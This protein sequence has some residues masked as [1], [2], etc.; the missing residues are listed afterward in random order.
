MI[1]KRLGVAASD[2]AM[3]WTRKVRPFD[4]SSSAN[5]MILRVPFQPLLPFGSDA[6]E[7]ARS[8]LID[9][10]ARVCREKPLEEKVFIAPSLAIGHQLLER[11]ASSGTPWVHLR[12]ETVRT[13]AHGL[14]GP[15]LV[16]E[17]LTLLSR[18][19]ALALVEHTSAESL[20]PDSYFGRLR[21]RPG[22]HRALQ[23]TLDE[24]RAAGVS[25]ETLPRAAFSDPRKHRELCEI[26][27]RYVQSLKTGRYVDGIEVLRRAIRA[28]DSGK[29][30]G[31]S[32]FYLLAEPAELS[33]LER[34]FLETLAG[35]K[36]VA[37]A[38][39]PPETW[40]S[41]ANR[42]RLSRATGKRTKSDTSFGKSSPRGSPL[43]MSRSFI[44]I[45]PCTRH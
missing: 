27:R 11:L 37:L 19:Q 7:P 29:A 9:E 21:H 8:R 25:E 24:L 17:G 30:P 14:I 35:E 38:T 1:P 10:L 5:T 2:S 15:S 34:H 12:V 43:M 4:A 33:L 26:L 13:L 41:A 22:L 44:R 36:L 20:A 42:A 18:A 3:G 39:D 23:A 16:E 6:A 32:A 40:R 28:L 45:P 31:G